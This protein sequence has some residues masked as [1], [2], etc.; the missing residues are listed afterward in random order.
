MKERKIQYTVE[1]TFEDRM[2]VEIYIK[3]NKVVDFVVQQESLIRD[4]WNAIIRYN[5]AHG[6]PHKDIVSPDGITK[7]EWIEIS[8]LSKIIEMAKQDI[9]KNWQKFRDA[10]EEKLK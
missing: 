4:K 1:I 3:K 7:K 10:Y 9:T 8:D 5:Y 6:K 2:R